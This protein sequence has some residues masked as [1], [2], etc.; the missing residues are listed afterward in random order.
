MSEYG[1]TYPEESAIETSSRDAHTV[2][3]DM[4]G[5]MPLFVVVSFAIGLFGFGC[6]D[7]GGETTSSKDTDSGVAD[8]EP[9][10]TSRD[11]GDTG[12]LEPGDGGETG[13]V[14][15]TDGDAGDGDAGDGEATSF[16]TSRLPPTDELG[17]RRG[18][19]IARGIIHS[20]TVFSHDAC[21]GSPKNEDGSLNE[22]CLDDW[23]RGV[24][25][26]RQ[27]YVFN[28]DHEEF[29]AT[30]PFEELLL[31]RGRDEVVRRDGEPVATRVECDG[32]GE[33]LV[34][35]GGEF[36]TMPVG[37]ERHLDMPPEERA[38]AYAERTPERVESLRDLGAV[39]LQAH[40]ESK[41]LDRL[42]EL[43]LDGFE[44]YNLHANVA[45][46]IREE[47]LGLDPSGFAS[48]LGSFIGGDLSPHPDLAM[49]AFFVPNEPALE[50]FDTLL[51]EG[52]RLVGISATD[53]HQNALPIDL[54]DGE[55]ADSFRR[56][57]RFFS[58]HLLVDEITPSALR[59]ALREGRT[60]SAFE[61]LGTPVGF[62]YRASTGDGV[63][64]MGDTVALE[65]GP[66]LEVDAPSVLGF[67]GDVSPTVELV[68]AADGGGEV[69]A[70][71]EGALSHEP[72]EAGAYRVVVRV[73][74]TYL[75]P[76]LQP[77]PG[78]F[79]EE[80]KVWIY[81]NPIY[82]E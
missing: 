79:L 68:R 43:K 62:D 33:V 7:P 82:V 55:R 56:M 51:A 59:E 14:D 46:D 67:E 9:T 6:A 20:H 76:H 41:P 22:A 69:V 60:Y 64:E 12:E 37:L 27:D 35:P 61:Y 77:S 24:C 17:E 80:S 70:T 65:E 2:G 81:G 23:R 78:E 53:S 49:L 30:A 26:T 72:E 4:S 57:M 19:R 15:A 48:E 75:R 13:G 63:A 11:G 28:T 50:K 3:S 54:R 74:P 44:I 32:G 36:G 29:A 73:L 16:V 18:R 31:Q 25:Q 8:D 39:V 66:V 52:Q 21:D 42:R 40:T 5:R 45:P 58:N 34:L 71:S 47:H 10:D 1:S 38:D